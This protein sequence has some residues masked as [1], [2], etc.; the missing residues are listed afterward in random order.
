[1]NYI[2]IV[3]FLI[4]SIIALC[5]FGVKGEAL[6]EEIVQIGSRL[7]RASCQDECVANCQKRGRRSGSCNSKQHC[8]CS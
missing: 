8:F 1:M 2:R 4:F 6:N 7:K 5:S 3:L